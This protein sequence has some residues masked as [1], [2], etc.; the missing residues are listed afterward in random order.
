MGD[1]FRILMRL[2]KFKAGTKL[3]GRFFLLQTYDLPKKQYERERRRKMYKYNQGIIGHL[4]INS[5]VQNS[6]SGHKEMY[7]DEAHTVHLD[8]ATDSFADI[9]TVISEDLMSERSGD[10]DFDFI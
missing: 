1:I 8:H 2:A 10:F 7:F 9:E 4:I 5:Y 3:V 6:R